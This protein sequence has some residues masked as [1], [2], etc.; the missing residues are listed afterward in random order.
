METI[1]DISTNSKRIQ[2]IIAQ[3]DKIEH[4]VNCIK[5]SAGIF[6]ELTM[7]QNDAKIRVDAEIDLLEKGLKQ[8]ILPVEKANIKKFA[9]AIV[10][11][12]TDSLKDESESMATLIKAFFPDN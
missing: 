5:R 10:A 8:P 7:A 6:E 9:K 2:D 1:T 4:F 11:A 3:Q 12:K